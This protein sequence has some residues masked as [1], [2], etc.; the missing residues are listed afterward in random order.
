MQ[1]AKCA[2]CCSY[3]N[4]SM[5]RKTILQCAR[6]RRQ[7]SIHSR[8]AKGLTRDYLDS[9]LENDPNTP[10]GLSSRDIT[11]QADG[12]WRVLIRRSK[13]DSYG[14][15]RIA[16]TSRPTADLLRKW[17]S[18]RGYKIDWLLC[19]IYKGNVIDRYLETTRRQLETSEC[20]RA[21]S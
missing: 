2:D 18:H 13:A 3:P 21:L 6:V 9:F 20:A 15:G 5:A 14:Q 17:L 16:I 4:R 1:P 7:K 8:Q 10:W 11:E 19:H 12:M